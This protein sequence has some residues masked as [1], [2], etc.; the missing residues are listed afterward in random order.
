MGEGSSSSKLGEVPDVQGATV[1]RLREMIMGFRV[2]QMLYVA[3]KLNLADHLANEPQTAERLAVSV[4]ADPA[5]LRRIMRALTS[6]GI[7]TETG[8]SF[9]LAAAGQLLRRDVPGS[10]N[11]LAVLYGENWLWAAY[12]RMLHS[13]RTGDAAFAHVHGMSFY[14][15][16]DHHSESATQFQ[17]AMT[18]YSRLEASAFADSYRF[19]DNATV[20][21]IGGGRGTLLA[22]LL[23]AYPTLNGVLFDQPAVAAGAERVFAEAELTAVRD[24][25]EEISSGRSLWRRCIRSQERA[26][27]LG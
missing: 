12:G 2:T 26:S 18:A 8:D 17:E 16:L 1:A 19:E 25:L 5:A 7:L 21:D 23:A 15:F 4:G 11:S 20:V 24:G 10:L 9:G 13:V 6:L 14:D 3:A 22:V 27:Q